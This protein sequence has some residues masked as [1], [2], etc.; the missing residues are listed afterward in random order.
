MKYFETLLEEQETLINVLYDEHKIRVYSNRIE[1][2]KNLTKAIGKP[3]KRYKKNK[4][5]W[6]GATWEIDFNDFEKINVLLNRNLVIEESFSEKRKEQPKSKTKVKVK[7][8]KGENYQ[9]NLDM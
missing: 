3:T 7:V 8:K 6:S 5:Y 4:T 1:V 9:L 2:I